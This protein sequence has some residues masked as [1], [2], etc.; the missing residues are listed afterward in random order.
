[1]SGA[2]DLKRPCPGCPFLREGR[3]VV[4]G[5]SEERLEEIVESEGGF[6]CHRTHPDT[7][8]PEGGRVQECAG[9]L[10]Y[11]LANGTAPQVMRIAE[12]LGMID[13]ATLLEHEDE[14]LAEF[15]DLVTAHEE[16]IR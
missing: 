16:M 10:I 5:L 8:G 14:V 3:D 7:G 2:Y 11:H 1:M 9:W 15:E 4:R 13:E 6:A 12:R